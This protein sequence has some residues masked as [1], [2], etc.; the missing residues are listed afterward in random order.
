LFTYQ[1][2]IPEPSNAVPL[3]GGG[4]GVFVGGRFFGS[5]RIRIVPVEFE[6]RPLGASTYSRPE[7]AFEGTLTTSREELPLAGR[8]LR[9]AVRPLLMRT[10]NITR[11]R[12]DSL[13]PASFNAPP[14]ATVRVSVHEREHFTHATCGGIDRA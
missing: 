12:I 6:R 3:G 5:L 2:H 10:G 14:G 4:G 7:R 1:I 13:L 9:I 8:M 11:P